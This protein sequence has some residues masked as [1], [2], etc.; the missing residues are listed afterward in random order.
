MTSPAPALYTVVP[1]VLMLLA[2]ALVPLWAPRWWESNRNKLVVAGLLGLPVL[3]L[4][5]A[6]R[7]H[8]A[9]LGMAEEYVSFIILLAGLYTISGGIRL[10]GD[11]EATPLT[12][13]VFLALGALL[14]SFIGT[15]G[16]SMLLI[17]AL[18]QTN[19]ERRRVKHTVIF[20]IFLVSN[21]GGMLTPLGDPPLFLGYLSGVPFAWTFRLWPAWLLMVL[22]LLLVYVVWDTRQYAREPLPALARDRQ[23][24]EPPRVRGAV[25]A[26]WLVGIV[27]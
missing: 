5:L 22:A 9:L 15:T 17:R 2:V 10:T 14:A 26:I 7:N 20:F 4:Y 24:V 27:L 3:L 1:F 13:T 25:N 16:A 23:R 18:L 6:R 12:N 8:A 11:L 21:V 19:R